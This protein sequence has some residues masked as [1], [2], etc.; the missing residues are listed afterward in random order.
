MRVMRVMRVLTRPN[1]GGPTRQA[2]ALWH[3]HA[4]LGVRTLLVVGTATDEPGL[5]LQAAGVPLLSLEAAHEAGQTAAG[6]VVVPELGRRHA[7]WADL[8]AIHRITD[9]LRTFS[10]Q[11]VHTH[12]TKAG[13]V[14]RRAARHAAVPVVAHTFHG[15]VL[16]DYFGP[17]LSALL[18]VLERRLARQTDLLFAVSATCR[19]ELAALGICAAERIEVVPPALALPTAVAARPLPA[20]GP[21]LGWV[22]RLAPIKRFPLYLQTLD[23]LPGWRGLVAGDGEARALAAAAARDRIE[24]LGARSDPTPV[25]AR[26]HVLLLPSRR[27]GLPLVALEALAHGVPVVG[28]AVPGVVDVLAAHFP[29]GLVAEGLGP[30]GLAAAVRSVHQAPVDNRGLAARHDPAAVAQRLLAAYERALADV[31]SIRVPRT[32]PAR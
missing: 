9:L 30:E 5:D 12:T 19:D 7:P 2:V 4:A 23:L 28:F 26:S 8:A 31:R 15:H 20:G 25:Y 1:L 17:V 11:V 13:L 22:G 29:Q 3:A 16:R 24:W 6:F 10:P 18:R 14:G 21:V 27:E 32:Q